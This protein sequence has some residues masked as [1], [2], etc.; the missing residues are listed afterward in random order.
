MKLNDLAGEFVSIPP[1]FAD[2]EI[3][4]ITAN[5][6]DV[7]PG[8]AFAALPGHTRDGAEFIEDAKGRGAS[9]VFASTARSFPDPGLPVIRVEDPR[10]LLAKT[11]ARFYG[12][13]PETMVAVTGT[14]GK[15]SVASFTRQIWARAGLPAAMVGTTG[16]VSP[17]RVE[18]AQLTTPDQVHLH[19]L[20][21]ELADEGVTHCAMEASSHGLD[22]HRLDGVRLSAGAFTNLGRDHLDYHPSVEAYFAAKMR[23]FNALLPEGAPAVIFSDDEWSMRAMEVARNAG[24]TVLTVGRK[25][26]FL[27]LK[28]V[29]HQRHQQVAEIHHDGAIY[30]VTVPLAGDFQLSNA[31]VAAGLAIATGVPAG[32]AIAALE[33]LEGASGRLELVASTDKG[34]PA[35]VDYAHKPE[36]LEQVLQS[37]R[38]FTTRRIVVVFGCGGDRDRG[39]RPIMGEIASRL[40]DTVIVTDDNPRS[41]DPASIRAEIL[42]AASG[43]TEIGDRGRAIDYAV[44]MLEEGDTLV[45]AGKGHEQGQTVGDK[46]LHFSDHE[47][48]RRAI[49]ALSD[50]KWLWNVADIVDAMSGRPVGEMPDGIN[51]ISIDS[52]TATAGDAF[53]AIKGD[54]FDGHDF[55]GAAVA[56]GA[57][58]LVVSE[59]KLP[60]LGRLPVPM[61]VVDDVLVAMARLGV[62]ARARSKARIIAVTGSVGK[63]TTKEMLRHVLSAQGRVHASVASFNNH[64]GVPLTLAR[65]PRETQFGIFEIGMNHAGEIRPLVKMVRPHIAIVTAI[66]GAHLGHFRSLNEIATTKAEIFEGVE[67]GGHVLLN[68]DSEKFAQLKKAAANCGIDNIHGFGENRQA[69]IKLL[70]CEVLADGSKALI[71]IGGDK[72]ELT[73]GIPGRHI[74]Q[75][76]LAVAGAAKF[77]GADMKQLTL[78]FADLRP[79]KGRG[80]RHSLEIGSGQFTV[81]DESY[82]AN[83]ASMRA[84]VDLLRDTPVEAPGRRIA[85]LGDMLELGSFSGKLH[86]ELEKPLAESGIDLVLLAGPEIKVL[87]DALAGP[88]T[89][90][91]R[92]T[93]EELMPVLLKTV[94]AGDVVMIKSSNGIGFSRLVS[95]LLDKYPP[96]S[97]S[98]SGQ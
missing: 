86:G 67:S 51:G 77:A 94:Q 24:L 13:Q 38:P 4:G 44:S 31:L 41:E 98:G 57:S 70:S 22:Q 89:H 12:T 7:Q 90:A 68:R 81:I 93:V 96:V 65:M 32:E 88:M 34:A 45:V 56:N 30:Q 50:R 33:H 74:V 26:A 9:A 5:S 91:Y 72:I 21:C 1:E 59:A 6:H 11:A 8:F 63:T 69:E 76:A 54:R 97:E 82:N 73:I 20:L 19:G 71:G 3:S 52:R 28:R 79:T 48:I 64:W 14:A 15:T 85:V 53:F 95:A 84:A 62:A 27:T 35:Y 66:A 2:L 75:N 37:V 61:I 58:L 36:A 78:A 16:V 40:A 17:Q 49:A 10:I 42:A 55:A 46:V 43:A 80:D 83:P 60:A 87:D 39:K 92:A 47:E 18:Y 25:G 23:L 29:E